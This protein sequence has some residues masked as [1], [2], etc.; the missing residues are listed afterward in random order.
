LEEEPTQSKSTIPEPLQQPILQPPK[1]KLSKR[2]I[3]IILIGLVLCSALGALS[4]FY[5][6]LNN[7]Y[8]S[9][10]LEHTR[11]Q[12]S[13]NQL[14]TN[15]QSLQQKY[16]DLD[17]K[18]DNLNKSYDDINAQYQSLFTDYDALSQVFNEP[19]KNK[20]VPTIDELQQWLSED[21]TD[22]IQYD[23]PN[24]ICGDF[25]VMLSQ[26]VKLKNWDMGIVTV[27]GYNEN[28]ESYG[29]AFNAIITTEGLRYV[30]PQNDYFWHFADDEEILVNRWNEIGINRE[31]I[32]V[33]E[34]KTV[35][36]FD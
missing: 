32:Y 13:H 33:E 1:R 21:K 3:S 25:S 17:A 14:N 26:H 12:S 2:V 19:L 31:W 7:K 11:L 5:C 15:F 34:Y 16:N 10:Q 23:Y 18:Y 8:N 35:I 30:E 27:Y 22:E 9:L 6:D 24:F 36:R 4:Y 20:T 28:H 29:H